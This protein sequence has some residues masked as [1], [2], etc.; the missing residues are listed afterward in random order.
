MFGS[1]TLRD[2]LWEFILLATQYTGQEDAIGEAF[3]ELFVGFMAQAALEAYRTGATGIE[4]LNECFSFGLV[5]ITGDMM[6]TISGDELCLNETWAGDGEV[7]RVFE[8][9]KMKCLKYVSLISPDP[10]LGASG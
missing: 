6:A 1:G 3:I 9:E 8:E 10:L 5:E 4:A 2:A 7:A